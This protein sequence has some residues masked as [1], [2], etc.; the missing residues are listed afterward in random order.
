[1]KPRDPLN[2]YVSH[3]PALHG[4]L[5]LPEDRVKSIRAYLELDRKDPHAPRLW[6]YGGEMDR[7]SAIKDI[8]SLGIANE[9]T[10][11]EGR[12]GAAAGT[13]SSIGIFGEGR[14]DPNIVG[15][16]GD[17]FGRAARWLGEAEFAGLES[18]GLRLEDVTPSAEQASEATGGLW[19]SI[20]EL[21][22]GVGA[23]GGTVDLAT[24]GVDGMQTSMVA[25]GQEAL[26]YSGHLGT[27]E[28]QTLAAVDAFRQLATAPRAPSGSGGASGGGRSARPVQAEVQAFRDTR[29][30]SNLAEIYLD[31]FKQGHDM[32][33]FHSAEHWWEKHL[34]HVAQLKAAGHAFAQGTAFAPGGMALVGEM[35][36][37]LVNLPRGS[38]VIPNP[39]LG[40]EVTVNVTVEGSVVA[41]RDLAQRIRQELIRT[42]RRTVD[43]WFVA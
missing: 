21:D 29:P 30:P 11:F 23:L 2:P 27:L 7:N 18:L 41:E 3:D 1:M 10:M 33:G 38:Q 6:E 32:S 15:W 37:E 20:H 31:Q 22:G 19:D 16:L 28:D 14:G 42:S 25:G 5:N 35:G 36:P 13:V 12:R 8:P 4:E 40:S 24:L 43:L 34:E 39:R 26:A 17:Q 9:I